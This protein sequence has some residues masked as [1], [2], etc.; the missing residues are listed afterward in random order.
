MTERYL[1][2]M[3]PPYAL[4]RDFLFETPDALETVI[5][6]IFGDAR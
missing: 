1:G 5:R 3:S 6:T 2:P 4:L